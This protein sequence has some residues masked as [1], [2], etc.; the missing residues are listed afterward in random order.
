MFRS[1]LLVA[2]RNLLRHKVYSTINISGLAIGMACCVL[3]MLYIEDEFSYDRYH[4]NADQIYKVLRETHRAGGDRSMGGGTSG[5]LGPNLQNDF[6]EV[7]G[8]VR[9]WNTW[10]GVWMKYGDKVFRQAFCLADAN[11]LDVFTFPLVK[12]DPATVL[13]EP[14]S[15]LITE[16]MVRKFFDGEDPI[17]KVITVEGRHFA[18]MYTITGILKDIPRNSSPSW[19]TGLRFDFLTSTAVVSRGAVRGP[20]EGWNRGSSWSPVKTYVMLPKGYSPEA[21]EE[22]LPDFMA[23]HMGEEVRERIP[24]TFSH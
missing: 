7:R 13:K 23:R 1:Y 4:K 16:E 20:W 5:A 14:F 22:K 11:I 18:G 2:I 17:G 15:V 12:G 8:A 24:T 6:S 10:G 3:I 9:I 21:L 19:K